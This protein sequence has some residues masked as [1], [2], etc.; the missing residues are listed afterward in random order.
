MI[1]MVINR[2]IRTL[3][4][5]GVNAGIDAGS[6]AI[7]KRRKPSDEGLLTDEERRQQ[8]QDQARLAKQGKNA[9]KN[10]RKFARM[11]RRIGKF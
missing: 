9:A 2:V 3:V 11:G 5:K 7:A 8:S 1:N 4:N 6:S 10:A